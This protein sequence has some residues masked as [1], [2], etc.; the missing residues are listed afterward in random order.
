ML[1]AAF[2]DLLRRLRPSAPPGRRRGDHGTR[3][4]R[5]RGGR[6][7][8]G[9]DLTGRLTTLV[10][11]MRHLAAS[12]PGV[13]SPD[14]RRRRRHAVDHLSAEDI[15]ILDLEAGNDRRPRLQGR[16]PE[17]R[18]GARASHARS[19]ARR[20]S[21]AASMPP[22]G[23]W[24]LV[25]SPRDGRRLGLDRRRGVRHRAPRPRRRRGR[26]GGARSGCA[27]SSPASS[28]SGSTAPIRCGGSM[29]SRR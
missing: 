22:L 18:R 2:A 12:P 15:R 16:G 24:R 13:A 7:P 19:A 3:T 10:A 1:R 21:P 5:S 11:A 9:A 25:R 28:R 14:A 26:T 6:V 23:C 27:R 29:S 17:G 8:C 4:G 20:M